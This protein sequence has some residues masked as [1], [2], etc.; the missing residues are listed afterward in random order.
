[1]CGNHFSPG[2]GAPW[3]VPTVDGQGPTVACSPNGQTSVSLVPSNIILDRCYIHG[4]YP[5]TPHGTDSSGNSASQ[6]KNLVN[7]DCMNSAVTGCYI[8]GNVGYEF[9]VRGIYM[10]NTPG[11]NNI[12]N[13]YIE[14]ASQNIFC[15]G[16]EAPIGSSL[17]VVKNITIRYNYLFKQLAW[18]SFA[19]DFGAVYDGAGWLVKNHFE[20]KQGDTWLFDTNVCQNN[21]VGGQEGWSI[22]LTP[23]VQA[24]TKVIRTL[25]LQMSRSRTI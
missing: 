2:N 19:A 20:L 10:V 23:R 14:A 9:E 16:D 13:N 17:P 18:S 24:P 4:P 5:N 1:M 25:M 7:L 8:S 6:I 21:W 22:L 3:D 12:L 15:G 11:G